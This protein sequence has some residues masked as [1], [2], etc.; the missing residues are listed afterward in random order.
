MNGVIGMTSVLLESG[1]TEEQCRFAEVIQTSSHS[2]LNL[3]NDIL[4]FSKI[5]AGKLEL[6]ERDSSLREEIQHVSSAPYCRG[7]YSPSCRPQ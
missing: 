4:G 1:L 2:L 7:C 6:E 3:L 5:E